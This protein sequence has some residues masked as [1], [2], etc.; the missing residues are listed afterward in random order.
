MRTVDAK[1][2]SKIVWETQAWKEQKRKTRHRVQKGIDA[3]RK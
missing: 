2:I 3:N 1:E